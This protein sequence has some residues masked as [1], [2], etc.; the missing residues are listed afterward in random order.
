MC[1]E[2]VADGFG[3]I[4]LK[5]GANLE[6]DLRR[7]RIARAAVGDD[8]EIAVD[9]NQ[10][11]D[12]GTAITWM[13]ALAPLAPHWIEEPT[14]PHDVLGTATIRREISPVPVATGEHVANRVIFKQLLQAQAIDVMQIDATRV[15]GVNENLANLLLAARFGIPVIPHA[16]GVGLCELV[17]HLAMFDYVALGG[18]APGVRRPRPPV[19]RVDRPPARALH[20]SG[21]R[22]AR[23]V[24]GAGDARRVHGTA[25]LVAS[26][27]H[28]PD[29]S[30]LEAGMTPLP[31]TDLGD[32][33]LRVTR[34]MFGTAPIGGLFAPVSAGD[35]HATL[36]AA[37]DA[38]IRAF[39]TA[40]HYGVGQSERRLGDFL[41][42]KPR[43]EFVISTKVGRLLVPATG[44][45]Q[46]VEGFYDTP[47]LSR[48]W[49]FSADGARRSVEESL[50]RLG[51]DR[52]DLVLIHDPDNFAEESLAGAY[53]ALHELRSS[54]VIGAIGLGM[55][56][57]EVPRWF[58]ARA[59]LDC[60]LIAGRY[61][62]LDPFGAESLLSDCERRQVCVL[63]G[64]VFNSGILADPRPGSTY[65][66][67]A[68]PAEL[69]ERAQR[70]KAVC[71]ARGLPVGAVALHYPLRHPAVTAALVGART[72]QEITQDVEYLTTNVPD[73]VYED[74]AAA[75]L[76]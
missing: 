7:L 30:R 25:S 40:P 24:P 5:V 46:G 66:Y 3:L 20:R 4:K 27:V 21:G 6:D 47:A 14:S 52:I 74:L 54:G 35:A 17:Q 26:R 64:G 13:R 73:A 62:L 22:A 38:G 12:V 45:T 63:T 34:L 61:T 31:L 53:P 36:E 8:V 39:D 15:A 56:Q 72:P 58:I 49:D 16:G 68:A 9:A 57:C 23:P 71:A 60:V 29:R 76:L 59:D 1:R 50:E 19:D 70:I 28:L 44:P 51:L 10:V 33:G 41:A 32:T 75:G 48:V 18:A 37:W 42:G 2:A 55:N 11:W 65:D 43:S 67:A 69:L